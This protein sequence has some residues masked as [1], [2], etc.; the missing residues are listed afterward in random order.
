MTAGNKKQTTRD[1]ILI[2]ASEEF[3]A[4]GFE[5]ATVSDI[6]NRAGVSNGSFFHAFSTKENLASA[7]YLSNLE[8][9]HQTIAQCLVGARG[10]AS[11][12]DALI[13]THI[14]WV[15]THRIA[16]RFLFEQAKSDWMK[17]RRPEQ[18]SSNENF[19][20]SLAKWYEPLMETGELMQ[21]SPHALIS[22]VIGPAQ[23]ICRGWL[24]G[25]DETPPTDHTEDLIT[26][27]VRAIVM[28]DPA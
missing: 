28:N 22:Q 16:A 21:L 19:R 5:G 20:A 4:K 6:R 17:D 8:N 25:R 24:S 1:K 12:I 18:Q 13:R 23:L 2:A 27:A 9:Y 14:A 11:G 26:C 3:E 10:A 7:L 15:T